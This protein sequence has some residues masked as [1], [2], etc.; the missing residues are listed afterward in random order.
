MLSSRDFQKAAM[1]RLTTSDFLLKNHYNRD[2]MYLAGYTVE[3]SLK[4]LIME[5]TPE[6]QKFDKFKIIRSGHQM[7]YPEP[8]GSILKDL[9]RP[10]PLEIVKRLR[11]ARWW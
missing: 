8:L 9:G 4:A 1:Q 7:H 3:C 10:I 6:S 2:A 5:I 11:R